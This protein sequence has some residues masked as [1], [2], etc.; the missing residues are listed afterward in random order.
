MLEKPDV[1]DE[2]VIACVQADY[3]LP[4]VHLGFLPLGGNVRTAVYR[5]V[6]RSHNLL[7]PGSH[8]RVAE[9]SIVTAHCTA[10]WFVHDTHRSAITNDS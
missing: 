3:G 6:I 10:I 5:A 7:A 9:Q 2:N 8:F 1:Q 4:I